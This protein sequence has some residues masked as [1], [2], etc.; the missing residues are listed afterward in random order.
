M[1][2]GTSTTG[3]RPY[4][5][6]NGAHSRG[7]KLNLGSVRGACGFLDSGGTSGLPYQH[8]T[9][10]KEANLP[11]DVEFKRQLS[12]CWRITGISQSA[13]S[14][15]LKELYAHLHTTRQRYACR[16]KAIQEGSN[17]LLP[18][19]P[20][21]RMI[22]IVRAFKVNNEILGCLYMRQGMGEAGRPRLS[23][24][25]TL[26]AGDTIA[27][28]AMDEPG[29]NRPIRRCLGFLSIRRVI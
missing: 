7:P 12:N 18:E 20:I 10:P 21:T 28:R 27:A 25:Y 4:T 22:R 3:F 26:D 15:L 29:T 14:P 17:D 6:D 24:G 5:S 2:K 13:S 23:S 11:P 19:R 16:G 9:Q 1:K 8:H